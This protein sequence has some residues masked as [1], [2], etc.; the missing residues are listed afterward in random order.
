MKTRWYTGVGSRRAPSDVLELMTTIA[1]Q[2]EDMG[3]I[4]R[5]GGAEGSDAA[6]ER[7][8]VEQAHS[9]IYRP[10]HVVGHF[11]D[12][13]LEIAS[14]L[15]PAWDRCRDYVR[16]LHARN[17]FQV[18]GERLN[19]PSDFVICWTPDGA[20][21]PSQM[22]IRTG[23]TGMAIRVAVKYHIP[24]LNLGSPTP[25]LLDMTQQVEQLMGASEREIEAELAD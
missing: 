20:I 17:V 8:V 10:Y 5:S 19:A 22:S 23:G 16:R 18:L 7:G 9:V 11:G 3:Y 25:I 12:Q 14:Q 6:F 13:A 24:V 21:D 2:M 1:G 15:H 4:L